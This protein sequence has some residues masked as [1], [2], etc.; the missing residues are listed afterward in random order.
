MAGP[1][2]SLVS[3]TPI[4]PVKIGLSFRKSSIDVTNA[5]TLP[6]ISAAPLPT[7]RAPLSVATKGSLSHSSIGPGGTTSV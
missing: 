4:L 2:S 3:I 5:A 7:I 6:F 1:S